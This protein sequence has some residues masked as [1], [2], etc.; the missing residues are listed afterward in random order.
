MR[1]S[2]RLPVACSLLSIAALALSAC[3]QSDDAGGDSDALRI[4]YVLPETGGIAFLGPGMIGAVKLATAEINDAGGV[5]GS[6][7]VLTGGDE[8]EGDGSVATQTVDRLL[9]TDTV[10]AVIGAAGSGISLKIIDKIVTAGVVQC[11]PSNT[12]PTFTDYDDDGYYFRAAASDELLAPVFAQLIV[13][14]GGKRVA[15]VGRA[16]DYAQRLGDLTVQEVEKA[17]A[18]ASDPILYDPT[19][20]DFD[21]EIRKIV[22]YKPDAMVLIAFDETSTILRGLIEA[23]YGPQDIPI[24][25]GTGSKKTDLAEQVEPGNKAAVEGLRGVNPAATSQAAF[26]DKLRGEVPDLSAT[27]F[28]GEAYDC[29]TTVAL[30][31]QQAEST[32]PQ[33]IRDNMVSVTEGGTKCT[34]FAD[35]KKLIDEGEDIDYD[36]VSGPI[37][38]ADN[39]DPTKATY[40]QWEF[41][42]DGSIKTLN[43]VNAG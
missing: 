17:G 3:A 15:V 25:V 32:D 6:D 13:D 21:A 2:K 7:V 1:S 9:N 20:Q 40:E 16:D 43:T 39:G 41:Q 31:A 18:D 5:L 34:T 35:C 22:S 30:A 37:D 27:Q 11:A 33:K 8:G 24:Y 19:A 12:S 42:S 10:S 14:D 29:V 38:L 23:G 36:G 4:G 28:T 26:L